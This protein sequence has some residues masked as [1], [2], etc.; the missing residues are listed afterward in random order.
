MGIRKYNPTTPG[1]RHGSVSDFSE[2]TRS[3]PEKSLVRPL[4]KSGGRNSYGRITSRHRGGGAKRAYRVIDFKRKDKDGVPAKVAHI[5]YDPNRTANI[6]LLHYADGEKRYILAP[7]GVKVGTAI[8]NGPK[9]DIKAGNCL[10]MRNIPLGTVIHAVELNPGQG[11]KLA[12]SAGSSI[13]L[14]AKEGRFAQLRMPSGEIGNVDM[15]CRATIGSVGNAEQG[16]ISLGKAGRA[17]MKGQRPKVRGVAM[18]PVDHPHG[19]GEGRTSGGRHPVSPWGKPEG[20]TR[21][22]NKP[23]DKLIVRRRRTGKKR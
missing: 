8:E 7:A 19:G 9:A 4:T 16:N 18:N 10:P 20:R 2:L 3:H 23:S 22:P 21:K 6:A 11:A 12:R 14:V 13:Q 17:R 5:E 1:R 15:D